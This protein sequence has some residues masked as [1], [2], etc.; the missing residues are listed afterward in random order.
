M[1]KRLP[2]RIVQLSDLHFFE[3]PGSCLHGVD[4]EKSFQAVLEKL[5]DETFSFIILSGDLTQE[6]S[7]EAY[8]RIAKALKFFQVPVYYVPGNHDD[9]KILA[10]V[11]PVENISNHRHIILKDWH[12][13]LL[14]SAVPNAIEGF[15]DR[16][17]L[18]YLKHCL[19]A[20]PEHKALIV[21]HHHL[22]PLSTSWI[23]DYRLMNA[24]EFWEIVAYYPNIAAVCYGHVH[25]ATEEKINNIYCYSAPSTC[26]QFKRYAPIFTIDDLS[27]GYRVVE[28]YAD[29]VLK[30]EV[31]RVTLP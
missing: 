14:N 20:Y 25:M 2:I 17:Q 11:F 31:K 4:T 26:V 1:L 6:G 19:Q 12:I 5:K 23:D 22:V 10:R 3:E 8:L 24:D 27:P 29:G 15:L 16:T 28:L 18:H 13:I 21:F 7:Y 9:S 30:T